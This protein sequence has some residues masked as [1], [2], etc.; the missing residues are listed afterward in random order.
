[1]RCLSHQLHIRF[2]E[3]QKLQGVIICMSL[4]VSSKMSYAHDMVIGWICQ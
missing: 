4:E 3:S 2:P 1:M